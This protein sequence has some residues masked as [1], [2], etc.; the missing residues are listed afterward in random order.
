M[1]FSFGHHILSMFGQLPVGPDPGASAGTPADQ[2]MEDL[3]TIRVG[4]D[5]GDS[6]SQMQAFS[7]NFK[8]LGQDVSQTSAAIH[9]GF[10]RINRYLGLLGINISG[11]GIAKQFIEID[12]AVRNFQR[13]MF[14]ATREAT[15]GG[16][17][18]LDWTEMNDEAMRKF[19][20][21]VVTAREA[22]RRTDDEIIGMFNIVGRSGMG[23]AQMVSEGV[24]GVTS[25]VDDL[26]DAVALGFQLEFLGLSTQQIQSLFHSMSI[27]LQMDL[28]AIRESLYE[29]LVTSQDTAFSWQE[30]IRYVEQALAR[31]SKL[32]VTI[33]DVSA[34]LLSMVESTRQASDGFRRIGM[35]YDL[36]MERLGIRQQLGPMQQMRLF[37]LVS[38]EQLRTVVGTG[39]G[40]EQFRQNLEAGVQQLDPSRRFTAEQAFTQRLDPTQYL[41]VWQS[42]NEGM[43]NLLRL[44]AMQNVMGRLGPRGAE[45]MPIWAAQMPEFA[46]FWRQ[47][48]AGLVLDPGQLRG[49]F[50]NLRDSLDTMQRRRE[51]A[52]ERLPAEYRGPEAFWER[53]D[54]RMQD[55]YASLEGLKRA[56][57]R[58]WKTI[59]LELRDMNYAAARRMVQGAREEEER[60]EQLRTAVSFVMEGA[61]PVGAVEPVAMR[62]YLKERFGQAPTEAE[63][64][65]GRARMAQEFATELEEYV[66]TTPAGQRVFQPWQF[67]RP[68]I[69]KGGAQYA[70]L[71]LR[72]F[73]QFFRALRELP[74]AEVLRG[75]PIPEDVLAELEQAMIETQVELGPWQTPRSSIEFM[76]QQRTRAR[77]MQTIIERILGERDVP[78][79]VPLGVP[80]PVPAVEEPTSYL[81]PGIMYPGGGRRTSIDSLKEEGLALGGGTRPGEQPVIQV[82]AYL[83]LG[84]GQTMIFEDA[85]TR[86]E[87]ENQ[88][89][90]NIA[91]ESP[92]AG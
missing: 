80:T 10:R 81:V 42:M 17:A 56:A 70:G 25:S 35:V 18:V 61:G 7:G 85:V 54:T 40:S 38:P 89:T 77:R 45:M 78:S 87:M 51:A 13:G 37:Q 12:Q 53:V 29:V 58:W 1:I 23:A 73:L 11:M 59:F 6:Q 34:F 79:Q 92:V 4:I 60:R 36:M 19:Y 15:R 63:L 88:R 47:F 69:E 91:G 41:V 39:A 3:Y 83:N 64:I 30:H 27:N 8:S 75:I 90:R 32:G 2:N 16:G 49:T 48:Q 86:V 62:G 57:V 31:Y 43:M 55:V 44:Q 72:T 14:E 50:E 9:A 66:T 5:S 65:T 21:T 71:T 52:E 46:T 24:D 26:A 22:W 68:E 20:V 82:T 33:H 84:A 76:M 74:E 67:I 28:G